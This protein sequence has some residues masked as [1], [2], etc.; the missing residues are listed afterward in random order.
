MRLSPRYTNRIAET[1]HRRGAD[2]PAR[3]R[4]GCR[5]SSDSSKMHRMKNKPPMLKEV[6]KSW[7]WQRKEIIESGVSSVEWEVVKDPV[8]RMPL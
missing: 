2:F 6:Q 1:N 4:N 5:I 7:W 3:A 8:L